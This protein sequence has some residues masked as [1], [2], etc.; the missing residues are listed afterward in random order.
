MSKK[1]LI[2]LFVFV[3]STI[4]SFIPSLWNA[5]LLSY[6]SLFLG[7]VGGLIGVWLGYKFGQ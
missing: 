4:G 6:S 1:F 2:G 5:D 3:G 7:G